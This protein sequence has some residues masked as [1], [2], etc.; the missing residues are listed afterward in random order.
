MRSR[1]QFSICLKAVVQRA[2]AASSALIFFILS[3]KNILLDLLR[4][5]SYELCVVDV[6]GKIK[7]G[8]LV[9]TT[10]MYCLMLLLVAC[11]S[12]LKSVGLV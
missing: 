5:D 12:L 11:K 1:H 2:S 7:E 6:G 9:I 8:A 4:L 10:S 3:G